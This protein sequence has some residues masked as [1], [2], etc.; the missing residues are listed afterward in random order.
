MHTRL[1]V[2]LFQALRNSP[3]ENRALAYPHIG[4]LGTVGEITIDMVIGTILSHTPSDQIK[5]TGIEL[6][7]ANQDDTRR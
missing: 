4:S 1:P 3:K 5:Q 7:T 2:T 6:Y